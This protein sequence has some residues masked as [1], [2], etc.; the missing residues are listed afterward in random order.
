[1][2]GLALGAWAIHK[3]LSDQRG[4]GR[5]KKWTGAMGLAALVILALIVMKVVTAGSP[6]GLA[7]TSI[8]MAAAGF[9]VAGL[10]GYASLRDSE[11]QEKIISPLYAADLIGGCAGSLLAS[12]VFIP[13][14]GLAVTLQGIIALAILSLLLL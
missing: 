9:L 14:L 10:F 6:A 4:N 2:A 11:N 7:L 5:W 12:L 1:M 8:L 3:V 13:F